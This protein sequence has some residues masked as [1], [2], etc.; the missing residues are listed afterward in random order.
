MPP[1]AMKYSRFESVLEIPKKREVTHF[2]KSNRMGLNN[3]YRRRDGSFNKNLTI[4]EVR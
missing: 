1:D 4:V 3:I 2:F